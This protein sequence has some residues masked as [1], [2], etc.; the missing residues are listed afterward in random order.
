MSSDQSQSTHISIDELLEQFSN[1]SSRKKRGLIKSIESR[2]EEI[3]S[4]G[5]AALAAFAI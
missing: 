3:S 5:L 4:L 2:A 1:G